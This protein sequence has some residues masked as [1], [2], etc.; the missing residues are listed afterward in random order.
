MTPDEK[1]EELN[2]IIQ[3]KDAQIAGQ[4]LAIMEIAASRDAALTLLNKR[5]Q[6]LYEATVEITKLKGGSNVAN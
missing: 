2:N 4:S 5:S 6:E 1:I 3:E